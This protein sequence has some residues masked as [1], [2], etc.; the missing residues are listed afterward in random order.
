MAEYS[1][2]YEYGQKVNVYIKKIDKEKINVKIFNIS[3][4]NA[5]VHKGDYV[6]KLCVYIDDEKIVELTISANISIGKLEF[7]DYL[8]SYIINNINN[9]QMGLWLV[10]YI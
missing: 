3:E 4:L 5:P 6:G 2:G 7:I 10:T 9:M 1:E 8:K